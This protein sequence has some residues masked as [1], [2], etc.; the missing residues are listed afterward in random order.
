MAQ[1]GSDKAAI[2][3]VIAKNS[4][5]SSSLSSQKKA[6]RDGLIT[7][8]DPDTEITEETQG[9]IPSRGFDLTLDNDNGDIMCDDFITNL[10][11]GIWIKKTSYDDPAAA[12]MRMYYVPIERISLNI[13]REVGTLYFDE[14]DSQGN[15]LREYHCDEGDY[16]NWLM[17]R[18]N[19]NNGSGYKTV[20]IRAEKQT[21]KVYSYTRDLLSGSPYYTLNWLSSSSSGWVQDYIRNGQFFSTIPF[22]TIN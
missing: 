19:L 21:G 2:A 20:Q 16:S 1:S 11:R 6:Y 17:F 10:Q 9:K 13:N 4:E 15:I 8:K 7:G 18:Y 14:Y 12:S 22:S 3:W 5:Q